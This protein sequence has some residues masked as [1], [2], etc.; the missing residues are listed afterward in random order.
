M[1]KIER[2]RIILD[3]Y[4]TIPENIRNQEDISKVYESR[5][6]S[7]FSPSISVATVPTR[8]MV[9]REMIIEF[10]VH[11]PGCTQREISTALGNS[12]HSTRLHCHKLL[13]CGMIYYKAT[14]IRYR[15]FYVKGA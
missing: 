5:V 2:V 10:I 8:T 7:I 12:I 6:S 9:T 3:E 4:M 1:N 14:N 13:K 15:K 11:N